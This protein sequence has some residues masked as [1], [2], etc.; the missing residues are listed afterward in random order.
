MGKEEPQ[1][2]FP[3]KD[4][5]VGQ[6]PINAVEKAAEFIPRALIAVEN[7]F[8]V[9]AYLL[10]V[11]GYIF[12]AASGHMER[13]KDY[14]GYFSVLLITLF[15][16]KIYNKITKRDVEYLIIIALLMIYIV[17]SRYDYLILNLF[18]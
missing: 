14:F 4:G 16:Y 8:S 5:S 18:K 10:S 2:K 1:I 7:K 6:L 12:I 13:F 9:V 17:F 11:F 15:F 3:E